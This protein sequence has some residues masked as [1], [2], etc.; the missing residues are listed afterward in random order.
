MFGI[1][2]DSTHPSMS[3]RVFNPL[4][5]SNSQP[6]PT[7]YRKHEKEKRRRYDQR[8]REIEYGRFTPLVF[9]TLGGTGPTASVVFK[10]I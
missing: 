3:C 2:I 1:M 7:C 9:D 10:I 8:L 5:P 6:L 4:A